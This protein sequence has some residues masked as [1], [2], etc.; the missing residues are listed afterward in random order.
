MTWNEIA[1]D[2]F[3][4]RYPQDDLTMTVV[5]GT[6]GLLLIDTG[7]SPAH[8][9]LVDAEVKQL[10]D[11][12]WVV[13]THAHYDHTFGNQHFA[14]TGVPIYG[15]HL[16]P[17]H[18][19]EH[20]R[21]RLA[22]WRAGTGSEPPRDW[23]DVIITPPT[24]LLSE[25]SWLDLGD[26]S[27]ELIPLDRGHTDGDLVIRVPAGDGSTGA[28]IVGDVIE[29]PGPPM[30][31]SG[32][33]PM[34]WP[35]TLAALLDEIGEDDIIVPGHGRAVSRAYGVAQLAVL[36]STATLTLEHYRAGHSVDRA[37]AFQDAWPYPVAALELAVQN[38]YQELDED[39]DLDVPQVS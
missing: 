11:V 36:E 16:L 28:W 24:R 2:V 39:D 18:L 30:Y 32:C 25:R 34:R 20:E 6:H 5:R 31:G 7:G 38:G 9:A 14:A 26:R 23:H 3:S 10:G 19:H 37:L 21:P 17:A 1:T 35:R 8:A 27:V 12:R 29:E 22:A 13:N 15:H 33:F 4:R